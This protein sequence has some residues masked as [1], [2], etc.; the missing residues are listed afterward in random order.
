MSDFDEEE[1]QFEYESDG[2]QYGEDVEDEEAILIEN[3]FYEAQDVQHRNP[4]AALKLYEAVVEKEEARGTEITWRFRALL[5][6]VLIHAQLRE[7]ESAAAAYRRLLPLMRQVTRNE[8]AEAINAVLEALSVEASPWRATPASAAACG[9]AGGAVARNAGAEGGEAPSAPAE[10]SPLANVEAIF[11]L[12]LEALQENHL[13][14]LWFR[15]CSRM[16]KLFLHQGEFAK[17]ATLLRDVRREARLPPLDASDRLPREADASGAS[18]ASGEGCE[19]LPAGQ[20]LEFYALESAV[21]VHEQNFPRLCRL[22]QEAERFLSEGI[23]DPKH[24][25]AI[26]EVHAK[27]HM[28]FREWRGALIAFSEAFRNFQEAG[29]ATKAK[30]MLQLLVLAS[31]LSSS[32]I[33]PLDTR[34]AK[35]LQADAGIAA[36]HELRKAFDANDVAAAHR[37]LTDPEYG[38]ATDPY[39]SLF[40]DDLLSNIRVRALPS[41]VASYAEMPLQTLQEELRADCAREVR[42]AVARALAESR[43]AGEIDDVRQ[44]LFLRPRQ[45]PSASAASPRVTADPGGQE[46]DAHQSAVR[47]QEEEGK[48][49][50]EALQAWVS[51]VSSLAEK[52]NQ[53]PYR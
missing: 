37:L 45:P 44:V 9:D 22:A 19:D 36:M 33:N 51:A 18:G 20:L 43:I 52:F 2:D 6:V 31:L 30:K 50:G 47:S 32:D 16:I 53:L 12:T 4:R 34:E 38:L 17:A 29:Q 5:N 46:A 14:R 13:K 42:S 3:S 8:T 1:I 27:I 7:M 35:A 24:V 23:A 48:R 49:E 40:T 11:K 39:I 26:R 41:I 10:A 21:C 28:A 15:T 25:A